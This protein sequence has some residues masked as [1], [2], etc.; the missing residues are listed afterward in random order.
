[1]NRTAIILVFIGILWSSTAYSQHVHHQ[2][3]R[4]ASPPD[5]VFASVG[6]SEI[7]VRYS[8]PRV[9]GRII[10]GGLVGY[11]RIGVTGAHKAT[12][13]TFS[14]EVEVVGKRIEAGS[15]A[16]FTIPGR[17]KWTVILNKNWDQHLADDYDENLDVLRAEVDPIM[18]AESKEELTYF[19]E[20]LSDDTVSLNMVWD[21]LQI[22][23][24]I[25]SGK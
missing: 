4:P 9:R 2:A 20:Q 7:A 22:S 23:L 15:Y 10:W 6:S 14:E 12:K 1:M 18:L 21:K 5:S 13:I 19:F 25:T 8:S 24:N 11:D 16:F 17:E 3:P